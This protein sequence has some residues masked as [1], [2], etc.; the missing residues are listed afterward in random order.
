MV[1]LGTGIASWQHLEGIHRQC[2]EYLGRQFISEWDKTNTESV[3]AMA[4]ITPLLVER[5]G[6]DA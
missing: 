5:M 4:S 1:L 2:I 6:V 3:L